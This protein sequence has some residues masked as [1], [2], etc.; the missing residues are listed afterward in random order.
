MA[1]I[2]LSL[3]SNIAPEHNIPAA[4]CA[5]FHEFGPLRLSSLYLNPAQGF[6]GPDFHNLV[7]GLDTALKPAQIQ[8]RLKSIEQALGRIP[9]Q[10]RFAS[11]V[12][13]I[14]LLC[15]GEQQLAEP[16]LPRAEILEQAF[17]LKPLAELAGP[18]RHPVLNKTYAELWQAFN[19]P[20]QLRTIPL[21]WQPHHC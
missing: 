10:Q 3:G 14:D 6:N 1:E 16:A 13:D 2:F 9:D 17:V 18:K 5:L 21:N 8:A 15:Y 12:L 19:K 20:D 11:R 7:V 4:L